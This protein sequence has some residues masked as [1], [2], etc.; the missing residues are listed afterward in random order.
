MSQNWFLFLYNKTKQNAKV[1]T[2]NCKL[3]EVIIYFLCYFTQI[4]RHSTDPIL[5][6]L[7]ENCYSVISSG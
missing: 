5:P 1:S 4:N 6:G 3:S 7:K 2:I